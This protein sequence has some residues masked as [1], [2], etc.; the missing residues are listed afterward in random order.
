MTVG[1]GRGHIERVD[2]G[3]A[4]AV[5]AEVD[6][7]AVADFGHDQVVAGAAEHGVVARAGVDQVVALIAE[8]AI[9]PASP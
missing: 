1:G 4:V 9:V 2:A 5:V 7:V 6:V 3:A 8:D